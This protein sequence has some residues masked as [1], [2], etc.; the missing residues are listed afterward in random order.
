MDLKNSI[1]TSITNRE[2]L[3][4]RDFLNIKSIKQ[5]PISERLLESY[6][7]EE[8]IDFDI[9]YSDLEA[10]VNK[11]DFDCKLRFIFRIYD[12]NNDGFITKI[13]LFNVLKSYSDC[14]SDKILTDIV[15][16]TFREAGLY[17]DK[18]DYEN[19]KKI[20]MSKSLNMKRL[21]EYQ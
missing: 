14:K 17:K 13:D 11:K 16:H 21:L 9:L 6:S 3:K 7:T 1:K 20:I 5:N 15:N 12:S 4:D 10:F 2:K 18:I 8:G 19:F